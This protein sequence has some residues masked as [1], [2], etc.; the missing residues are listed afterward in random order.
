MA[1]K[2]NQSYVSLKLSNELHKYIGVTIINFD[3][4]KKKYYD[5][6]KRF[7]KFLT[8][9]IQKL[10]GK[11]ELYSIKNNEDLDLESQSIIKAE[12]M[13]NIDNIVTL[14]RFLQL[15]DD[16]TEQDILKQLIREYFALKKSFFKTLRKYE[17]LTLD[18]ER[19][20]K[21]EDLKKEDLKKEDLK[22]ED[23]K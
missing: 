7:Y 4:L 23:L 15:I 10:R 20:Q 9:D 6:P 11:L 5:D 18:D 14:Q 19:K 2:G 13:I 16:D 8:S 1:L 3:I 17:E 21:K 12:L 22:K